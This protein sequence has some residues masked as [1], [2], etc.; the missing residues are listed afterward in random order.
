[1]DLLHVKR[2]LEVLDA[3]FH[4]L[5][6]DVM[7][8]HFAKNITLS[9]AFIR[10]VKSASILPV[11]AH[12]MDTEPANYIDELTGMKVEY[13][14]LHLETINIDAFRLMHRIK[15]AGSK[16]GLVLNPATPLSSAEYLLAETDILTIMTVD[17][18]YSGQPFIASM[19]DKISSAKK[20]K[21]E[22]GHSYLIQIDGSCNPGTYKMLWEAG[23]EVFVVGMTGLFGRAE[24]LSEACSIMKSDFLETAGIEIA[25]LCR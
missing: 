12:L 16:F 14:S 21:E 2:D 22:K 13:I 18:G 1:M 8:G 23:A 4:M 5:H 20:L 24:T 10:A 6:A 3:N 9:P 17:V 19:L 7:D 15:N 25:A 11:D